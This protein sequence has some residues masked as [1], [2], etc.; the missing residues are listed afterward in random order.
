M[1]SV[2][3]VIMFML[4][5]FLVACQEEAKCPPNTISYLS[6]PY[7]LEKENLNSQP[8]IVRI[9]RQEILMDEVISGEVCNDSWAGTVYV[10]C[11]I[12][13]PAWEDKEA[14]FFEDCD[15]NVEEGTII[16]VEAHHNQPYYKGCSCHE[17][18]DN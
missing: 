5:L 11:N 14:L 7:S 3:A 4:S 8:Q 17:F 13:I 2:F 10:T 1:K 12:Q 6:P 16:Y 18:S 15:L 9:G